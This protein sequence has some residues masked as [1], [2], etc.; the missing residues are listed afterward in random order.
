MI[1]DEPT[2]GLDPKER[3]RFRNMISELKQNRIILLSTH[4]VSDVEYIA[5]TI[6]VMQ[7]GRILH[8][9]SLQEILPTAEGRIWECCTDHE[10]AKRL[11]QTYTVIHLREQGN[12]V[13]LRLAGEKKPM[14]KARPLSPSLEDLYLYYFGEQEEQR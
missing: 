14:E 4:I 13:F 1:L 9:G 7:K 6:A 5:D 12:Q 2:S 8:K 3:V 11:C 10:E